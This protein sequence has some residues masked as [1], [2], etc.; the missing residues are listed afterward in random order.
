MNVKIANQF[1]TGTPS[2]YTATTDSGTALAA[3]ARRRYA[4]V[5]NLST[6]ITAYL[7]IG[8]DA[9]D[10]QGIPVY[11]GEAY[12]MNATNLSPEAITAIT[13]SSTAAL[14]ILEGV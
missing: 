4:F 11:P 14:A 5:R 10:A 6:T 7:S 1:N 3:N 12:E 2:A 9:V 8:S 13:G